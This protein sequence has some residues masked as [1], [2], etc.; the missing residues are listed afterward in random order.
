MK[1]TVVEEFVDRGESARSSQRPELQRL[2]RFVQENP[3]SYAIVHKVDRLARNRV[4][5]VE[6]NLALKRSGVT[7]VSVTENIDET[8]SGLLLHGIMSSI[9]EFYSRNLANEV[10]KGSVQKAKAGGT[11]GRAPVGYINVHLPGRGKEP[12]RTVEVDPVRGPLMTKAFEAY[13]TGEW[14]TRKLL[15]ELSLQG[16]TSV[17]KP[18][19][20][21]KSLTLSQFH[22][23]LRSPY[24]IGV[25]TYRGVMYEGKHPPLVLREVWNQ[26]QERLSANN[27]AGEKHREHPH[28]LKGSIFCGSCGSR[29]LVNHA[30][31]RSGAIY[32][33][34]VCL[35]RQRDPTSCKQ[36]AL[37]IEEVEEA[38]A[39]H[40]GT[41]QLPDSERKHIE[42]F[43][44]EELTKMHSVA[45][46][47]RETQGR[48]I[49]RLR[50]E[51]KKL[52]DAHYAGAVPLDL[53]KSE[54]TRISA[55]LLWAEGRL[56][57]VNRDFE[58][59]QDNLR[60]TLHLA[61]N[62]RAAYGD[63]GPEIRRLFNQAFFRRLLIDED[64]GVTGELAE[65]FDTLLGDELRR[66]VANEA[67]EAFR[68]TVDE[69]LNHRGA[70]PDDPD[71]KSRKGELELAL[72]GPGN[73]NRGHSVVGGCDETTS[74]DLGG[75]NKNRFLRFGGA[76]ISI[77]PGQTGPMLT[78]NRDA[79]SAK[80][81]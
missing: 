23:L 5:D 60:R 49:K 74:V 73:D 27:Y 69:A 43:V 45:E 39:A 32:E 77:L 35:G 4:D 42:E 56:E 11:P 55:E 31:S 21:E 33:Y 61:G 50:S 15:N 62:C 58:R 1:A 51:Q 80:P 76:E 37:L 22:R 48:R 78:E 67:S 65:P 19:Q 79:S 53:L 2:L 34:F 70:D 14:T 41:V 40:Y 36:R 8:P 30:K 3:V 20:A 6:I 54:Q 18:R 66:V 25:V 9:A 57:T 12:I 26:V 71:G 47:E 72:V 52:L 16:L 75:H 29:L 59:V 64:C 68:R 46:R 7:L 17:P 10:I 28:Y 24:Y 38:V 13:A 44:Q 63:A 81:P